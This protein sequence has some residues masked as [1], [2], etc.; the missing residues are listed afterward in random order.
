M[1]SFNFSTIIAAGLSIIFASCGNQSSDNTSQTPSMDTAK[2]T[3]SIK[4]EEVTYTSN[5]KQSNG[6]IAYDENRKGKLPIVVVI[7]EWWG[8]TDYVKSRAKQ[9]AELGYFA[10]DADLFG[11]GKTAAN[12]TEAMALTKPYY[13]NPE[14]AQTCRRS[15]HSESRN[16]F[17]GRYQPCCCYRLLFWRI[18][19]F[20]CSQTRHALERCCQFSWRTGWSS[21]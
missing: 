19:C 1:K 14:L 21:T 13:T 20:E 16:F 9:L 2:S 7:P 15:R 17:T 8:V 18:H 5:G 4:T 10:I 3:P 12:P 6:F 11:D